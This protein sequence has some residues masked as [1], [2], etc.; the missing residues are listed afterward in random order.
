MNIRTL[1][2][3]ILYFRDATGYEINKAAS[4]GNFSHFIMASYGSIYPTL[5]KME[6][7]GLV[8]CREEIETGKPTRKVYS[9]NEDGRQALINAISEVPREDVF[10]SEFLF[11]CLCSELIEPAQISTA[12]DQ[13]I[14][15]VSTVIERLKAAQ[16]ECDHKESQ[17]AIN[18]GICVNEAALKY[19]LTNRNNMED[20][21][22][23]EHSRE[24]SVQAAE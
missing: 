19:L 6:T 11:L 24:P 14:N 5:T 2:L 22:Q 21:G 9:L 20:T 17:F 13:Q 4:E 16:L 23:S 15:R 10:K 8:S 1:C 18:Y 3:G 12:I 7:D